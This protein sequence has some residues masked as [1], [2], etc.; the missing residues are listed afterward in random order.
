MDFTGLSAFPLTPLV[1][2]KLDEAAY[3]RLIERLRTAGVDSIGALGSTGCYPYFSR[4]ER[5]TALRL[6]T[7]HSGAVPVIAGIGALRTR[8]VLWLAEDAQ[9][10]GVSALLLAPVSYHTLTEDEVFDLYA[11][12]TR[13]LSVPLCV[14]DN[15]G[16]THFTFSDGLLARIAQLPN[17][18]SIKIPPVSALERIASLRS[19]I[20]ETVTLG[21]SGDAIAV[22]GLNA[23]CGIWYS[24]MGG[25]FPEAALTIARAALAGDTAQAREHSA[26]LAP[27]WDLFRRY[28]GSLRVIATAAELLGAV[29]APCLPAPLRTLTG[30]ARRQVAEVIETL[31]LA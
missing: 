19:Q 12:V 17:I 30:D 8:D 15:P 2:D 29:A 10:A 18:G 21:I 5:A 11:A 22:D 14:Y 27:L 1:D 31:R 6:A 7:E 13:E 25:L 3:V 28:G 23:G 26:A 9:K 20:P 24:V 4:N 16:A